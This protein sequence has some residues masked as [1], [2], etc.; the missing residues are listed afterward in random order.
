MLRLNCSTS[1]LRYFVNLLKTSQ[2][3]DLLLSTFVCRVT[4][5]LEQENNG[6]GDV[7]E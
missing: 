1:Y 5:S 2:L 3:C 6:A 7:L 4:L